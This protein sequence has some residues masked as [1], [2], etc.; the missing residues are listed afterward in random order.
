MNSYAGHDRKSTRPVL[1][2]EETLV[3]P[4]TRSVW[5]RAKVTVSLPFG[6]FFFRYDLILE[7]KLLSG[8]VYAIAASETRNSL[9][10]PQCD[11]QIGGS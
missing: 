4:G 11:S 7:S 9:P 6:T 1:S 3:T 8:A 5:F 10:A 2:N